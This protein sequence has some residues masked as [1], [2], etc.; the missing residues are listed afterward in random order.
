MTL[1]QKA[2]GGWEVLSGIVT[3]TEMATTATLHFRGE[4]ADETVTVEPYAVQTAPMDTRKIEQL[5]ADGV[6]G[7]DERGRYGIEVA[8]PFAV[9]KGKRIVGTISVIDV[10]GAPVEHYEVE[11]IPPAPPEPSRSEKFEQMAETFGLSADDL[12]AE[13]SGRM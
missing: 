8:L 12:A 3:L 11:D 1:V 10:K 6:W 5:I 2:E 4:R 7:A 9:P 13:L